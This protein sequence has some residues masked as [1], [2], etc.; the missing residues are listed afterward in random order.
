VAETDQVSLP[1]GAVLR[2][3]V[4]EYRSS[5]AVASEP[6]CGEPVAGEEV[7]AALVALTAVI[8]VA[9]V[10]VFIRRENYRIH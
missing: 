9:A 6:L 8:T 1:G 7:V 5:L 2:E 3:V 10:V 4:V